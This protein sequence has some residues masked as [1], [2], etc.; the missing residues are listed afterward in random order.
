MYK[1]EEFRQNNDFTEISD[2]NEIFENKKFP[3][4]T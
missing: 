3:I 2:F 1:T 4:S